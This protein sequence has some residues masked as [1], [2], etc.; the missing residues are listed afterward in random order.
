MLLVLILLAQTEITREVCPRYQTDAG[1]AALVVYLDPTEEK[2]GEA[3][4]KMREIEQ[5][6]RGSKG[7]WAYACANSLNEQVVRLEMRPTK[8]LLDRE[9][10]DA[11]RE[12][13]RPDASVCDD[14]S[15]VR[16]FLAGD[17]IGP[18]VLERVSDPTL[19]AVIETESKR[20]RLH[21]L[22][23]ALD[24]PELQRAALRQLVG[25][26]DPRTWDPA[27][28][29][30]VLAK[31]RKDVRRVQDELAAGK[32]P[33]ALPDDPGFAHDYRDALVK[34]GAVRFRSLLGQKL[35]SRTSTESNPT[36]PLAVFVNGDHFAY[37]QL[38]YVEEWVAAHPEVPPVLSLRGTEKRA[39]VA[40]Q[41]NYVVKRWYET[42][43]KAPHPD[44]EKVA[45][46]LKKLDALEEKREKE[47][48]P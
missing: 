7:D 39:R 9:L 46:E 36:A 13:A 17:P 29:A 41:S 22:E 25:A 28:V 35:T 43:E 47:N 16:L 44:L 40:D 31:V 2:R 33:E 34:M 10:E 21:R 1:R 3:I 30:L 6:L 27:D 12:C 42:D 18:T 4:R 20:D 38:Q 15:I 19:R 37:E 32:W 26:L 11:R 48:T 23:I 8:K 45:A 5:T 24:R 14:E